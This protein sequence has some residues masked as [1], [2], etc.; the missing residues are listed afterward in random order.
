M[1]VPLHERCDQ[2]T[3]RGDRCN[4]RA[5]WTVRFHG[6]VTRQMCGTHANRWSV[7][8]LTHVTVTL[9]RGEVGVM[10]RW[11]KPKPGACLENDDAVV[12]VIQR[13]WSEERILDALGQWGYD[14][15]GFEVDEWRYHTVEQERYE[16][17]AGAY[18]SYWSP[19]GWGR[20]TIDVAIGEA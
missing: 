20:T 12:V 16:G 19:D 10:G 3:R 7:L 17:S 1:S 11:R 2:D 15:T 8:N 18:D 4:N 6:G 9:R 13:G 5:R 14:G